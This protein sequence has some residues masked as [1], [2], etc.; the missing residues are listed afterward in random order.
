MA[1]RSYQAGAETSRTHQTKAAVGLWLWAP[2]AA[3]VLLAAVAVVYHPAVKKQM[4][5]YRRTVRQ[6]IPLA[7]EPGFS[8][9]VIGGTPGGSLVPPPPA[10]L[11]QR[12]FTADGNAIPDSASSAASGPMIIRTAELKLT[13]RGFDTVRDAVQQVVKNHSGYIAE[14]SI[15]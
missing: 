8:N 12:T 2:L 5:L 7:S 15:S 4:P 14:L 10:P 1:G 3:A 11:L 9:G 6:Q 13:T